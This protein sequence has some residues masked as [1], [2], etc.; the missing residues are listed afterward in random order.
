[1]IGYLFSFLSAPVIVEGLGL[2]LFGIWALTGA[3]AQYG[4]L[5][6]LGVG[7][8][9]ARYIAAHHDDR[10]L[11]GEYMT[12]GWLSV[13]AIA[14]VL[15]S[16]AL[17]GGPFL[18]HTLGGI[19]T[20]DMRI[21]LGSSAVLLCCSMLQSIIAAYPIGRRRMVVP[22]VA[23][24]IFLAVNFFASVG[25]IALGAGLPGYALANAGAG[26][27]GVVIMAVAVVHFE[28]RI[29]FAVPKRERVRA[30]LRFSI[31][32]QLV[33]LTGLINYQTDKIVIAFSV[34]PQAAGAYE[35]ANRVALA[36]RELGVYAV[37]AVN[38]EL[39]AIMTRFGIERVRARYRRLNEVTAA[40]T[41]PPVMLVIATAPLLLTV[42]LSHAPPDATAV[43]VGLSV[44]YLAGASTGVGYA[45]ALAA[46]EPG[47][48]ARTSV[49]TALVNIVL[50]A[51][52]APVFGIWGVLVG[53]VVA[54]TGGA[55]AQV[56]LVQRR[57]GLPASDYV[58]A[59]IPALPVYAGLM[60]P[61]LAFCYAS[62]LHDR[63]VE[64]VALV[65]GCAIYLLVCMAWA[66][67]AGR[68]PAS[69]ASRV[70]MAARLRAGV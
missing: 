49:A 3:L 9:L 23:L 20:H 39:T 17:V 57:F 50:T 10:R 55:I 15:V 11:C 14:A 66:V 26:V 63:A 48:V 58:D 64:A 13:A 12:I 16:L 35:L 52:L 47:I 7:V 53:T 31:K 43:L 41:L 70:P 67:R 54:L 29:P 40:V 62:P 27:A 8:S 19:S 69:L 37:S 44:A 28:G 21:V 42:W 24:T 2:R 65:A 38:I 4:A 18:S 22:N 1:M 6:D 30:F 61:L 56:I 60:L 51:S 5:L 36:V 46:A 25:S 33:R 59:V 68:L 32:N 45:V 34:G